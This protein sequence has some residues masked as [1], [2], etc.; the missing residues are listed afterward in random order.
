MNVDWR[1][2]TL[3]PQPGR[4]F[5]APIPLPPKPIFVNRFICPEKFLVDEAYKTM[6]DRTIPGDFRDPWTFI[7]PVDRSSSFYKN[8]HWLCKFPNFYERAY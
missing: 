2:L 5:S 8:D 6:Y 3:W 4:T 7:L 1:T